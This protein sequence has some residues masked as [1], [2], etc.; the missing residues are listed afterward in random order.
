MS[1]WTIEMFNLIVRY[2]VLWQ[3]I[4]YLFK[5]VPLCSSPFFFV[6]EL[7]EI[8]ALEQQNQET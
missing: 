4:R 7:G 1:C 5:F 2:I 6:T 8:R 3:P